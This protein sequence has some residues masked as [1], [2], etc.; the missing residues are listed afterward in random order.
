MVSKG[1]H[2]LILA[3][4]TARRAPM[5]A[6][7]VIP[8]GLS[9]DGDSR[10]FHGRFHETGGEAIVRSCPA[11]ALASACPAPPLPVL[12]S[13]IGDKMSNDGDMTPLGAL[14]SLDPIL[15]VTIAGQIFF[16][17]SL[18]F[19]DVILIYL[20]IYCWKDGRSALGDA[21]GATD[22]DGIQRA[23]QLDRVGLQP[24]RT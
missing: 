18:S 5:H 15:A 22:L 3:A 14:R 4:P 6:R 2:N 8:L 13:T 23:R 20:V 19:I 1:L 21:R 7:Q 12:I 10:L 17:A 11:L 16:F 9:A 24:Q